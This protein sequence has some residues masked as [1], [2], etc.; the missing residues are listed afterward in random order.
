MTLQERNEYNDDVFLIKNWISKIN[1]KK[2]YFKREK[3]KKGTKHQR[4]ERHDIK[5][6]VTKAMLQ[7]CYVRI[8]EFT[9]EIEDIE[10]L[11]EIRVF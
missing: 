10:V 5:G 1:I 2:L 8:I 3:R 4:T 7:I 6:V 9:N 11:W